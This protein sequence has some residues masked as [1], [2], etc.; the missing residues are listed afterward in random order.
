MYDNDDVSSLILAIEKETGIKMFISPIP[1]TIRDAKGVI[2]TYY[3]FY[4]LGALRVELSNE[5]IIGISVWNRISTLNTPSYVVRF[6][7]LN[8]LDN[9]DILAKVVQ[10]KG[11]L[12]NKSMFE[13]TRNDINAFMGVIGGYAYNKPID[14]IYQSYLTWADM[15]N[16]TP[17]TASY[18]YSIAKEWLVVNAKGKYSQIEI[19]PFVGTETTQ[20]NEGETDIFEKEIINNEL[21]YKAAI[22]EH[23]V[24]RIAQD[25]PLIDSIFICGSPSL[26]KIEIV[27]RVLNEEGVWDTKTV[28]NSGDITGYAGLLKILW[29]NRSNRIIVLDNS[30]SLLSNPGIL[31]TINMALSTNQERLISYSRVRRS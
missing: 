13:G 31:R 14:K 11:G 9:L 3:A 30:D 29:E 28:Y 2:T 21:Y 24:R 4:K 7:G 1:L 25:D 19:K 23:A 26:E 12:F 16:K 5:T 27:K 10:G 22:L 18:F 15:N 20:I 6:N 17:I 8:P